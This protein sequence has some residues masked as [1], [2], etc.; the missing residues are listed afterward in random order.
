MLG[1]STPSV[2]LEAVH[3]LADDPPGVVMF[4]GD[5]QTILASR[6]RE[7]GF[8]GEF[9]GN[10]IGEQ[11]DNIER[12]E[13]LVNFDKPVQWYYVSTELNVADRGTSTLSVA[14]DLAQHLSP[15][16]HT[17]YEDM[18]V[19][20]GRASKGFK[21]LFQKEYL[22]VIMSS[23]RTAW[24]IMMWAHSQDHSGVDNTHLTSMQVAWVVFEVKAEELFDTLY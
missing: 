16:K 7:K 4:M 24:L 21:Q 9:F 5:S 1:S 3:A 12:M 6:E 15:M 11:Y 18:V 13:L 23:T 8:F 19:V 22:H 17:K 10:R 20:V 2:E 14:E